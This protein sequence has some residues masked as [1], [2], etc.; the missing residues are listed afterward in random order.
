[1]FYEKIRSYIINDW[2]S[3]GIPDF[4]PKYVSKVNILEK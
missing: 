4:G 1:M 2:G 3:V